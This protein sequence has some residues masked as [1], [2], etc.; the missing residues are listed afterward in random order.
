[1]SCNNPKDYRYYFICGY[2]HLDTNIG[3][4]HLLITQL[5]RT[6]EFSHLYLTILTK[7]TLQCA[8][9]HYFYVLL[10]YS[11][12]RVRR[13]PPLY[14]ELHDLYG[15]V[16]NPS[17]THYSTKYLTHIPSKIST[18]I[19]CTSYFTM[20]HDNLYSCVLSNLLETLGCVW[21]I[22]QYA[23]PFRYHF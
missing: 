14:V 12:T 13:E 19:Y 10:C 8:T 11:M 9:Q 15:F 22:P 4:K 17:S 18:S 23:T 16:V 6:Q 1:M 7:T 21:F 20:K 2:L 3:D 5:Y